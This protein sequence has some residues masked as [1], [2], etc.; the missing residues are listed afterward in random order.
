[1]FAD[2]PLVDWIKDLDDA[3]EILGIMAEDGEPMAPLI[4]VEMAMELDWIGTTGADLLAIGLQA[5]SESAI[6][7]DAMAESFDGGIQYGCTCSD[8]VWGPST[9]VTPCTWSVTS[10]TVGNRIK[11]EYRRPA[12]ATWTKTGKHWYCACC[13]CADSGTGNGTEYAAEDVDALPCPA[14]PS[15]TISFIPD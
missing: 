15:G 2:N 11:C 4:G 3:A 5:A 6:R 12:T 7:G 14:S 9:C 10:I 1:M 13:S 8:A